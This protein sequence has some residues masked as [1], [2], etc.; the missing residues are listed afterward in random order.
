MP[1]PLVLTDPRFARIVAGEYH[2]PP[3]VEHPQLIRPRIESLPQR[4]EGIVHA[5]VV[6]RERIGDVQRKLDGREI[7]HQHIRCLHV[8]SYLRLLG[9]RGGIRLFALPV[10]EDPVRLRLGPSIHRTDRFQTAGPLVGDHDLSP[11][12][13]NRTRARWNHP[14]LQVHVTNHLKQCGDGI[15]LVHQDVRLGCKRRR[16]HPDARSLPAREHVPLVDAR[17]CDGVVTS[18]HQFRG[19]QPRQHRPIQGNR[20]RSRRQ[21]LERHL[22]WIEVRSKVRN[23]R[24]VPCEIEREHRILRVRNHDIPRHHLPEQERHGPVEHGLQL[25]GQVQ[26]IRP[27]ERRGID[28]N[29]YTVHLHRTDAIDEQREI[30]RNH[31]V[32]ALHARHQRGSTAVVDE[33]VDLL[34]VRLPGGQIPPPTLDVPGHF[35]L[36][37]CNHAVQDPVHR[38]AREPRIA[39]VRPPVD[40]RC[41]KSLVLQQRIQHRNMAL[42]TRIAQCFGI[43]W[44]RPRSR[45]G[46]AG[47]VRPMTERVVHVPEGITP[48]LRIPIWVP[49][50]PPG[51]VPIEP[52][53]THHIRVEHEVVDQTHLIEY[54][55]HVVVVRR[56]RHVLA[57]D[58][59]HEVVPVGR[60]SILHPRSAPSLDEIHEMTG[61]IVVLVREIQVIHL[62]AVLINTPVCPVQIDH[63]ALIRALI[64]MKVRQMAQGLHV[65]IADVTA[66]R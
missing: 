39:Q 19:G 17:R 21:N 6:G 43:A 60:A 28:T 14:N 16:R 38:L 55:H 5:I 7:S 3:T 2:L 64:E 45:V 48:A 34:N 62:L 51:R 57:C 18:R 30:H 35:R 11:L 15:G 42:S 58:E 44:I 29:L 23:H 22:L 27:I 25:H 49:S 13:R 56:I 54:T 63:A 32:A 66:P 31:I 4:K 1:S 41:P 61:L 20:S 47:V 33:V 8:E 65:G 50:S 24:H 12:Q 46:D 52:V 9:T 37:H 26:E 10:V 36:D 59:V 53:R 40:V